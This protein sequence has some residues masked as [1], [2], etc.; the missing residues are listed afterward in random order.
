MLPCLLGECADPLND[1]IVSPPAAMS[2]I[3]DILFSW[4]SFV[5]KIFS[6][7]VTFAGEAFLFLG[8]YYDVE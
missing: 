1:W 5:V 7:G 8:L 6:A 2:G 3:D 4:L